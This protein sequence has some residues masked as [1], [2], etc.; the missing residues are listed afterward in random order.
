MRASKGEKKIYD[1]LTA[2]H[3]PFIE[4][5]EFPDLMSTSGRRL[6]FDFA[7]FSRD[8]SLA[9]LIEFQGK[10]HYQSIGYFK[11]DRGLQRQRYNDSLKRAYCLKRG[12]K[13]VYIP[14]WDIDDITYDYI[15]KA[16]GC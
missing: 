9:Y 5:Y 12:I 8:G 6:R 3:V 11:G 7:V 10:Q 16:A 1:I 2:N 13:I 14:Y 15:R 4:E